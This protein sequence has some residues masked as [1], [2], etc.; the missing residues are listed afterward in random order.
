ML[1]INLFVLDDIKKFK[2][3]YVFCKMFVLIGM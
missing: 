1:I 2:K 3:F